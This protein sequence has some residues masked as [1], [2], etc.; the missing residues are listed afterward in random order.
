M[1]VYKCRKPVIAAINGHAVGIGIT[2]T[3]PMDMRI[4]AEDAKIGFVF[5]KRGVILEA[6]SSW[7]LPRIIGIAKATE[8]AYT[9]RN[10]EAEEAR[11]LGFVNRV[12]EDRETMMR[13]VTAIARNIATKSPLAVRGSKEMLLFSRDHSV[14][15]GL[16]YIATWNSGMLSQADLEAGMKAQFEKTQAVYED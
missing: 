6:C 5:A 14:Q 4:V 13:E 15:E 11:E 1:A 16:N 2:M 7:F 3:L 10:M 12:F 8:L 9:G